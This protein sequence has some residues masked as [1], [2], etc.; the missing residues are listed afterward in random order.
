MIFLETERLLFRSHEAGD[1]ADF[2]SMHTDPEVRRYVGGRAWPLEEAR[3]RFREQFL[4]RP[5]ETYGLWATVFKEERKYIGC[6]GLRAAGNGMGA[7]LAY[8]LARPYWRLGLASEASR[9]FI[10][11]AFTRLGL[12][13]VE[14]DVEKGHSASERILQKFGFK[15]LRREEIPGRGRIIDFYELTR[16]QWQRRGEW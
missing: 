11:T 9:A 16:A 12:D 15:Y 1:E 2:V 5:E 6:C 8:Y 10:E 7:S 3:S 14:A 4:D 13:R